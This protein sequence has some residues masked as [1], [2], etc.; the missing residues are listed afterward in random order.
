MNKLKRLFAK[1]IYCK[2]NFDFIDIG[3]FMEYEDWYCCYCERKPLSNW[4]IYYLKYLITDRF[5]KEI[6]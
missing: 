3:D 6:I 1:Y 5:K 4:N 2:H